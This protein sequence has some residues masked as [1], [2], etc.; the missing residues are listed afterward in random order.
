MHFSTIE[1]QDATHIPNDMIDKKVSKV[2]SKENES[3][4]D[5]HAKISKPLINSENEGN[6]VLDTFAISKV[7]ESDEIEDNDTLI[8]CTKEIISSIETNYTLYT[9]SSVKDSDMM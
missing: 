1:S 3:L 8:P 7:E 5:V 6:V 2:E 4:Q 9:V